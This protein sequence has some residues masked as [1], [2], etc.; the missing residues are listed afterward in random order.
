MIDQLYLASVQEVSP[1]VI[2]RREVQESEKGLIHSKQAFRYEVVKSLPEEANNF[3][4][5]FDYAKAFGTLRISWI[6]TDIGTNDATTATALGGQFGF[7]TASFQGLKLH[8]AAYTSQKIPFLNPAASSQF[9]HDFFN[10]EG[11]SFTYLAETSL[12]YEDEKLFARLGRIRI[13]TPYADSDDIRMAPNTFEGVWSEYSIADTLTTQ[14]YYLSRWA[15]FDSADEQNTF[16]ALFETQDGDESWGSIGASLSYTFN[17][18]DEV[19]LWYY[20]IDK[21]SDIVYCEIAGHLKFSEHSH[22]EYGLQASH[23]EEIEESNIGGDVVGLMAIIDYENFFFGL[24]GNYAFVD[25]DNSITNGFG[26]GPYY[27]SLDESTIGFVS[28]QSP[29]V[30]VLSTRIGVGANLQGIGIKGL[31]LELVHGQIQST[32]KAEWF[33]ENDIAFTYEYEDRVEMSAVF[34]NFDVHESKSSLEN[35]DFNRFLIRA[36]YKF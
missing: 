7:D 10:N 2:E 21:M 35:S 8:V 36:D 6:D 27:T 3:N 29:G 4:E 26:G 30:D 13:D 15:G 31:T 33:K 34:A 16:K 12:D 25:E 24:A 20:H 5:A 19:S 22:I 14:I 28:E 23:I 9:N 18:D 11:D 17:T 32:D 1:Q